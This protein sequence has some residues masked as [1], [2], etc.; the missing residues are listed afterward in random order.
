M[1]R[2]MMRVAYL[3][4]AYC[5]WQ[6][7]PNGLSIEQVLNE[8]LSDL[9]GEDIKV[10]GA[11]RTDAGVHALM[12]VAVFDTNAR[13]PGDKISFAMNQRLP[14]DIV[15]RGSEEVPL[16]F[17]PRRTE[18]IKTYEYRILNATFNNPL[19]SPFTCF[20]YMKLDPDLMRE[21]SGYLVGEHD[22]SS[23][24]AP[25]S[26]AGSFVRNV[27]S[28]DIERSGEEISILIKGNGFLY[29]MVRIIAGTLMEVGRGAIPPGD[30]KEILEAKDR[31]KAGPTAPAQGLTLL[32]IEYK[33]I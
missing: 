25:K 2:I 11:S 8:N 26:Q 13:M 4:T 19:R 24:C 17:H 14:E 27:Y 7:Q 9:L 1:K 32:G 15:I 21:A 28:I 23:F 3:G 16:D 12:N 18:S 22:F 5:G 6:V 20:N 30:V 33:Q 10:I 29:N 31:T